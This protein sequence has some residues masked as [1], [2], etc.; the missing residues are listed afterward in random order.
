[1]INKHFVDLYDIVPEGVL[2]ISFGQ[3][4]VARASKLYP[5]LRVMFLVFPKGLSGYHLRREFFLVALK[6]KN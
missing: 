5:S 1:M 2:K 3:G 4:C 6:P